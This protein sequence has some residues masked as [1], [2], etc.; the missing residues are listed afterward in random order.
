ML[1][2]FSA[3]FLVTFWHISGS[4]FNTREIVVRE[5]PYLAAKARKL[6]PFIDSAMIFFFCLSVSFAT[7]YHLTFFHN[8]IIAHKKVSFGIIWYQLCKIKQRFF[9]QSLDMYQ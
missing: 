4:L 9:M 3:L 7:V 5:T 2:V 1:T 8:T 6:E